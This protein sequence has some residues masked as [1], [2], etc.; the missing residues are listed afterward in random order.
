MEPRLESFEVTE[1]GQVAPGADQR[2]LGRILGAMLV[3]QDAV[4][5]AVATVDVLGRQGGERVAVPSARPF[6]Q[7]DPHRAP[8]IVQ[9]VWPRHQVWSRVFRIRSR[10]A[11]YSRPDADR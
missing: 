11:A 2:L 4:R 9:P 1:P 5:E 6:D 7:L 8:R 10:R 3:A